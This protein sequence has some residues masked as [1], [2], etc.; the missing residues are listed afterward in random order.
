M[1]DARQVADE[2]DVADEL[3]R[4]LFRLQIERLT[5]GRVTAAITEAVVSWSIGRGWLP[6]TEARVF[7]A[8][9]SGAERRLGRV[10][11][12]V[13]RGHAGPDLAIE[14]DSADKAWS[15]TKLKWLAMTGMRSIWI[16]WGDE[17]WAGI[18]DDVDV[19]QLPLIRRAR[20]FGRGADQLTLPIT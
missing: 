19:I 14:I 6:R 15:V 20:S 13:L 18:Y 4:D 3:A 2:M 8:A 17:G 10:D 11:V 7:F 12:L 9:A 1:P 5:T 16:R